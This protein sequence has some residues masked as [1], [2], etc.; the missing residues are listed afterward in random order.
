MSSGGTLRCHDRYSQSCIRLPARED[1]LDFWLTWTKTPKSQK[2][3]GVLYRQQNTWIILSPG[4]RT[5]DAGPSGWTLVTNIPWVKWDKN[6]YYEHPNETRYPITAMG[7]TK[8]GKR[9]KN[10]NLHCHLDERDFRDPPLLLIYWNPALDSS[11]LSHGS[12]THPHAFIY[13]FMHTH[14]LILLHSLG[15]ALK[16]SLSLT[17]CKQHPFSPYIVF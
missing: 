15:P 11:P 13:T 8:K 14:L 4:W 6:K 16:P 12:E 5:L 1:K 17:K 3:S 7:K 9:N 2:S 10:V